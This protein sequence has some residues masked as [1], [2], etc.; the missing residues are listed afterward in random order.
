MAIRRP[1]VVTL[2]TLLALVTA[3]I[4]GAA[5]AGCQRRAEPAKK[6]PTR[7]AKAAPRLTGELVEPPPVIPASL[8]LKQVVTVNQSAF[9]PPQCYT[10]TTDDSGKVHNPCYTC[11]VTSRAPNFINDPDIQLGYAFV[12][13]ARKN[14]WKNLLVDWTERLSTIKDDEILAYVRKSNYF[15]DAGAIILEKRLTPPPDAWD[16]KSDGKWS[17]YVPDARFR[18][19]ERG[20]DRLEDGGYTGWRAFA[21]YPLPGTF[22][23]TNGSMGDVMIRLPPAFRQDSAG[24]FSLPVYEANLA[25]VEALVTRKDVPIDATDEALAGCDLDQNGS[26]GRAT[27][28]VY[29]APDSKPSTLCYAGGARAALAAGKVHL[30]DGL[31]PEGTEFLHTVRYLDPT[32]EGIRMAARLKELRYAKKT[33]WFTVAQLDKRA[34]VEAVSKVDSPSE[35]RSFGGDIGR[36]VSNN[37]GWYFQGFIEDKQGD[38]RPQTFEENVYCTGCHGGVGVTDDGIFSY[39]RRLGR[40]A[41]QAGFYHWSQRGLEGVADRPIHGGSSTEY[42]RYLELNGAGDEFRQNEEVRARFFDQQ[43]NLIPSMKKKLRE[44]VTTVLL[45]SPERALSLDKAYRLLVLEQTFRLGRE[46]VLSG[47]REVVHRSVEE[48]QKTGIVTAIEPPW[49]TA[50]LAAAEVN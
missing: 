21:Y 33:E 22:W 8:A 41:F 27:R 31:Y 29:R 45:P 23:P 14:A 11:H 13:R 37:Q 17:G 38:L 15:D 43:G 49:G 40:S 32:P 36:G 19:D 50:R 39:S 47:A 42:V 26:V 6:T 3:G 18:F 48:D 30:G 10:K 1:L 16:H 7:Y 24:A 44:D 25:V 5:L 35:L 9:I 28:V 20:Y 46:I 2:L 34:K 4:S 12:P